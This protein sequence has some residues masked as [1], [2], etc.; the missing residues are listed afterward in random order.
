[1]T[2]IKEYKN[3]IQNLG[4]FDIFTKSEILN[5]GLK[6]VGIQ[7]KEN[8]KTYLC[9]RLKIV[10][11]TPINKIDIQNPEFRRNLL[12]VIKD[13]FSHISEIKGQV[14]NFSFDGKTLEKAICIIATGAKVI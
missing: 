12:E 6:K 11:F 1:M 10:N 9:K 14:F 5:S 7:F 2:L 8:K 3:A 4:T 13:R